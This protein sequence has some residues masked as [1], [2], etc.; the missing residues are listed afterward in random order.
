L[1][2][3]LLISRT[4]QDIHFISSC[5]RYSLHTIV[6]LYNVAWRANFFSTLL[7]T[8]GLFFVSKTI[9]IIIKN[10]LLSLSVP[11]IL[12]T[13]PF[14]WSIAIKAD[15][16]AL[17]FFLVS[18]FIFIQSLIIIKKK[19]KI[20]YLLSLTL[21][22]SFTNHL[23]SIFILPTFILTLLFIKIPVKKRQPPVF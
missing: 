23:L 13:N 8:T 19:Y 2:I 12:G 11:I 5:L 22:L 9:S 1:A 6:P 20:L 10:R 21:G 7:C 4:Q 15:P 16:H 3:I 17:H 14:L 18:L